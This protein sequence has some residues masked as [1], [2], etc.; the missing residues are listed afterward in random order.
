[1]YAPRPLPPSFGYKALF[2]GVGVYFLSPAPRVAGWGGIK[3]GP[4]PLSRDPPVLK[5]LRRVT[6]V[7]AVNLV[8]RQENAT[9]IAQQCLFSQGKAA[10]KRYSSGP[11]LENGLDRPENRYARYGFASF[12][13][14]F[15]I[16]RR[17]GWSQSFP[18]KIFFSCS[19]GGGGR[20]FSVPWFWCGKVLWAGL[21]RRHVRRANFARF[22]FL[23][24]EFFR[25]S[26]TTT[27]DRNL[28]FRGAV[29]TGGSPLDFCFFSSVYVYF[30]KTSPE[31]AQIAPNP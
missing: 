2:R 28:Q 8:R 20:H 7:R 31:F 6:S 14:H 3:F 4:V 1:M 12:F 21:S 10:E 22:F 18:L 5:L 19:L 23:T 27:R 25:T 13:Q 9:E 26:S 15:H 16:Y 24:Y 17:V 29:S 11:L 30:S